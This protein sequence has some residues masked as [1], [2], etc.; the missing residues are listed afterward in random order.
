[1]TIFFFRIG[2]VPTLGIQKMFRDW[3]FENFT[4]DTSQYKPKQKINNTLRVSHAPTNRFYK[5]S[6][7]IIEICRKLDRQGKIKFKSLI[8]RENLYILLPSFL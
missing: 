5:G 3:G 2:V 8:H 6:K 1:M 7:E 4:F